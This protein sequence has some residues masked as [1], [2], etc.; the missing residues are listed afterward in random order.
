M[1][2]RQTFLWIGL[3]VST[4]A[5]L[6]LSAEDNPDLVV[7]ISGFRSDASPAQIARTSE[8]RSGN[9]GMY[10]LKVDFAKAGFRAKFFNWNGTDAG[11]FAKQKAPG[12]AA[13]EKFIRETIAESKPERLI[14]VSNSWGGHTMLE[15]AELLR[16]DPMIKISQAFAVDGSSLSR[17]GRMQTLPTN[18]SK[19]TSYYTGNTFCWGEWK[20]EPRVKNIFL[21]EPKN[22]FVVAGQPDYAATFDTS[23]H[24]AAEWD[25]NIHADIVKRATAKQISVEPATQ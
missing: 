23:A 21:G 25:A 7:L 17:G 9:A 2:I 10:E 14:L 20:D 5:P 3:I 6:S 8:F 22:G 19:L 4:I 1:Y 15:V 12:S 11:Q 18:I 13:I 16:A 24:N